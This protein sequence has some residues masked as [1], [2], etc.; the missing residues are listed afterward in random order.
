MSGNQPQ[1]PRRVGDWRDV[2]SRVSTSVES[3]SVPPSPTSQIGESARVGGADSQASLHFDQRVKNY[4]EQLKQELIRNTK[5]DVFGEPVWAPYRIDVAHIPPEYHERV[6]HYV[7]QAYRL[8]CAEQHIAYNAAVFKATDPSK[9][10]R[11]LIGRGLAGILALGD[12]LMSFRGADERV[13][14]DGLT[15]REVLK[16]YYGYGTCKWLEQVDFFKEVPHLEILDWCFKNMLWSKAFAF[17]ER[18]RLSDDD[19]RA[20]VDRLFRYRSPNFAPS[21]IIAE[22]IPY[23]HRLQELD[24]GAILERAIYS[25]L[26]AAREVAVHVHL[27]SH[28]DATR[29]A[30]ACRRAELD[31][32]AAF[33]RQEVLKIRECFDPADITSWDED[34]YEVG[35]L[36]LEAYLSDYTSLKEDERARRV[37][38]FHP[39]H[40]LANSAWY[41]SLRHQDIAMENILHKDK[42]NFEQQGLG[43]VPP[44]EGLRTNPQKAADFFGSFS[45]LVDLT[46]EDRMA[47]IREI[48]HE[49]QHNSRAYILSHCEKFVRDIRHE[50]AEMLF[51]DD[52]SPCLLHGKFLGFS[53]SELFK[54]YH[55]MGLRKQVRSPLHSL[56]DNEVERWLRFG[57]HD[58]EIANTLIEGGKGRL[59]IEN[60]SCFTGL[61]DMHRCRAGLQTALWCVNQGR[62][63]SAKECVAMYR[64]SVDELNDALQEQFKGDISVDESS[65]EKLLRMAGLA[66]WSLYYPS[67]L[68][69]G[70]FLTAREKLE[71]YR[72]IL[73]PTDSGQLE[74]NAKQ[75]LLEN[76]VSKGI[77]LGI[78]LGWFHR[79]SLELFAHILP[80]FLESTMGSN[81]AWHAHEINLEE[82]ARHISWGEH[83]RS[84]AQKE[85]GP[86]SPPEV[87]DQRAKEL[88]SDYESRSRRGGVII[89]A[90]PQKCNAEY[91]FKML[92]DFYQ[93][94]GVIEAPTLFQK[95]YKSRMIRECGDKE[96]APSQREVSA[97]DI[98]ELKALR[99]MLAGHGHVPAVLPSVAEDEYLA[100]W[101]HL[102]ISKSA[103][104]R[105]AS[106]STNAREFTDRMHSFS[107]RSRAG[108]IVS[109]D[110]RLKARVIRVSK[111]RSDVS[112]ESLVG[113]VAEAYRRVVTTLHQVKRTSVDELFVQERSAVREFVVGQHRDRCEWLSEAEQISPESPKNASARAQVVALEAQLEA[114]EKI[115]TPQMLVNFLCSMKNDRLKYSFI[116]LALC[117]GLERT[118][119]QDA[120]FD[121][122]GS[123]PSRNSIR[124]VVEF[125]ANNVRDAAL[126]SLEREPKV[127]HAAEKFLCLS[128]FKRA[129][130][131]RPPDDKQTD[132]Q[133]GNTQGIT[134]PSEEIIVL[135]TRGM[136]A[137]LAGYFSDACWIDQRNLMLQHPHATALV[138]LKRERTVTEQELIEGAVD[139]SEAS[140]LG[141]CYI[142]Q[143]K[144]AVGSPVLVLRGINPRERACSH[145]DMGSFV[146]RLLDEV[147]VPCAKILGATKVVVP[148]DALGHAQTNRERIN[149]YM[150][151]QYADAPYIPL[152]ATDTGSMFNE[153]LIFDKCRVVRPK[154]PTV[155]L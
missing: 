32:D 152:D 23:L 136:L 14:F 54:K 146:E 100:S 138:F 61:T 40:V 33:F 133:E 81:K 126:R 39:K 94:F 45:N 116:R 140:L 30:N 47:V 71:P 43:N 155:E 154:P 119:D 79:D 38:D 147:V 104:G 46:P 123:S 85:M 105:E 107:L 3:L 7:L 35:R 50:V 52:I 2:Q 144:D 62:V 92:R 137:E 99:N 29:L 21:D 148:F 78:K 17:I 125:I 109:K 60:L 122:F 108:Q 15:K 145:L 110:Q 59:I 76:L 83:M 4:G 56:Q 44:H 87:V 64:V 48:L 120:L 25:G 117:M 127:L 115:E 9:L 16:G 58:H 27:Y 55:E 118:T 36:I 24:H 98:S 141:A 129:L 5:G 65:P 18:F 53:P 101:T 51:E 75:R 70:S 149:E 72:R 49:F 66:A 150:L 67:I 134:E 73:G 20:I 80:S 113:M 11:A 93:E 111:A 132:K 128:H 106:A 63:D 41:P 6:A 130:L 77:P 139:L 34:A 135:P 8:P 22:L 91:N 10:A 112:E 57:G 82:L 28:V 151:K 12:H 1:N 121:S 88:I 124:S 69:R 103:S 42:Y 114:L 74:R 19:Q 90:D 143:T 97:L 26:H 102:R 31:E 96:S 86:M 68:E 89:L 13:V 95:W 142:L 84:L 153:R 131:L 37:L